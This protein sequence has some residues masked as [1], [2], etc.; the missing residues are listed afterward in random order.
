MPNRAVTPL[1]LELG[2][3][4]P[5]TWELYTHFKPKKV[6]YVHSVVSYLDILGFRELIETKRAGEI[7]R[8]VRILAESV[9]P[10][11]IFGAE[12][13]KFTKFSDTVLR[14]IPA[15]DHFARN[16]I[17]EL[18]SLLIAQIA[19]IS[20]G[21]P[22]RGSITIGDVVQSW[23]I[24]YGP[25]V[26]KAYGLASQKDS[27]PRIIVDK[28]ALASIETAVEEDKLGLEL[29]ALLKEDGPI[30]YLDYL[31]A[32]ESEFNVPEQ[33]FPLFLQIHRDFI[34]KGLAKYESVPHVLTKYQWLESYHERTLRERFGADGPKHLRV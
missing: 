5:A 4:G 27:P 28:D 11:P 25:A 6:R 10:S 3:M 12:K 15:T 32:C 16:F 23:G 31:G 18:R 14:S 1:V 21:I 9:K 26:V 13:I 20:E 2:N 22:L 17:F 30:Y 34:R 19:L 7:S 8:I 24:V 33:E 29:A